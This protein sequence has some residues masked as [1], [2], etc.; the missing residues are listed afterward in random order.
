MSQSPL[1]SQGASSG[2]VAQFVPAVTQPV[3]PSQVKVVALVGKGK[4]TKTI[5]GTVVTRGNTPGTADTLT[6]AAASLPSTIQDANFNTYNLNVDYTLSS[7]NISWSTGTA[8]FT[9]TIDASSGLNV[10]GQTFIVSV[11]GGSNQTVTFS[12]TNPISQSSIVTQLGTLTGVS[13]TSSGNFVKI[14][15][16]ANTNATL[17]IGNGTSN[18]TLGFTGGQLAVGPK[19]PLAAVTYS[20]DYE[21][22]KI[23]GTDYQPTVFTNL[24][25]MVTAYGAVNTTNTLSLGA[26]FVFQNSEQTGAIVGMQLDPADTPDLTGFRNAL[27]KLLAVDGINIV[28]CLT[29]DPNLYPYI[30]QHVVAASA[31]LEKK[32]RTAIVGMTGTPTIAQA[33][34]FAAGFATGG[35]GRRV[36]LAYPPSAQAT[37]A[38][39]SGTTLD[40]SYI[41]AAIAG[42]RI[43]SNFD[44]AEPLLRKQIVGFDV[45]TTGM[46]RAQK[47][48]LRNGG[49]T[50]VDTVNGFVRVV[51]DTTTDRT[52]ADTQ[53][54]SVTEI[55]D[56]VARTCR[57]LLDNI[58]IGIKLL[59]D[60][61]NLLVATLTT[62]LNTFVSLQIINS[63][64]SVQAVVNAVDQ[65]EIDVS[66]EIQPTRPLRFI[67]IQFTI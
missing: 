37:V 67:L 33:Q 9:S 57:T 42:V 8:S 16:S 60:T 59:P 50:V 10:N 44:V 3:V 5:L 29:G 18:V 48:Q 61:P 39:V 21:S 20:F 49:I 45:L 38:G 63:F 26:S 12:G 1:S 62:I 35:N 17:L 24:N 56:F 36:L 27:N 22:N 30:L 4:T 54:F 2:V 13:V 28:V 7:G 40:G 15:T 6:P 47:L 14:A 52:S 64:Q 51:E 19:E 43:D 25:D 46:T 41:A 32:E 23:A 34:S 31:P 11:N 58:F 53:E 65:R 66:F 55:I